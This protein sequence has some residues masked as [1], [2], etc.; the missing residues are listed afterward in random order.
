MRQLV[1]Y[2]ALT[3]DGFIAGPQDEVDFFEGSDEYTQHMIGNYSDTL[4]QH[5]RE[6][7]GIG[8]APLT[9]FDTVVMGRRT[10]D[11]ALQMG[12][13]SPY[14]H[15]RQI[16]FSRSLYSTDPE[17]LITDADPR[18]VIRALKNEDSPL[19]IYLAGGGQ[20]AASLLPEID[21]IIIKRYPVFIGSGIRP[22]GTDF[23]P[24]QFTMT[25]SI[26]FDPGNSITSFRPTTV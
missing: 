20:L 4:P 2:V 19:D 23:A 8:Q 24:K 5:G 16:V 14:P 9:R 6:Q 3:L 12:I 26:V 13:A 25:K 21:E 11:P 22:F 18:R 1:Y 17:V 7:L 10:Y 15:L